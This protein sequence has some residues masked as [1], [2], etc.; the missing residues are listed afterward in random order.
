MTLTPLSGQRDIAL[1]T[2]REDL[3]QRIYGFGE[4]VTPNALEVAVSRI[5][6]KLAESGSALVIH[7]VRGVGVKLSAPQ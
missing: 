4:E 2:C 1:S 5:R 7:T 6:K 3:E